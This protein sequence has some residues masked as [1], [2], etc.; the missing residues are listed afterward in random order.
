[1]VKRGEQAIEFRLD[2]PVTFANPFFQ[3]SPIQD[4]D[5]AATVMNQF[6]FLQFFCGLCNAFAAYPQHIGD[7]FLGHDQFVRG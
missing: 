4:R 7:Q 6:R 5:V 1:M 2:H 3:A